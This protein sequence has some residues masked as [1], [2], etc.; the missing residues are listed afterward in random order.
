MM[1]LEAKYLDSMAECATNLLNCLEDTNGCRNLIDVTIPEEVKAE[2]LQAQGLKNLSTTFLET[3]D[4]VLDEKAIAEFYNYAY[5]EVVKT[6]FGANPTNEFCNLPSV[7]M[8]KFNM[9]QTTLAG[10]KG[11][12]SQ[13]FHQYST[14]FDISVLNPIF[15]GASELQES[16]A[17]TKQS[18]TKYGV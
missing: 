15:W 3:T 2:K 10:L 6:N 8:N 17:L 12:I 16:Q 5:Q 4:T 9:P 14:M 11:K 18:I 13:I 7:A 1:K